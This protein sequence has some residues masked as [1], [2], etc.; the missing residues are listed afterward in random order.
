MSGTVVGKYSN[1]K[2]TFLPTSAN[3]Q[4]LDLGIIKIL[5][6][7][8]LRA[9][10]MSRTFQVEECSSAYDIVQSVNILVHQLDCSSMAINFTRY[11]QELAK[12]VT[13]EAAAVIKIHLSIYMPVMIYTVTDI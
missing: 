2:I 4:L 8:L 6:N 5:Q 1:I 11:F 3:F 9:F 10:A 13:I 7:A 12:V